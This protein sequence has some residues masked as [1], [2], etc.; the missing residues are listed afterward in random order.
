MHSSETLDS[1][2]LGVGEASD[3]GV[4]PATGSPRPAADGYTKDCYIDMPGAREGSSSDRRPGGGRRSGGGP[5]MAAG[6]RSRTYWTC[7]RA[8]SSLGAAVEAA[9][10][11]QDRGS[12]RP[13]TARPRFQGSRGHRPPVRP[14]SG[15]LEPRIG[16]EARLAALAAGV[17]V[18]MG[19]GMAQDGPVRR[20]SP[21]PDDPVR[22]FYG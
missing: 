3:S 9:A 21:D 16:T 7:A 15:D 11:A 19:R 10:D 18:L 1:G 14:V 5:S 2:G 13:L 17:H 4:R 12:I 8:A 6:C 22:R 20:N